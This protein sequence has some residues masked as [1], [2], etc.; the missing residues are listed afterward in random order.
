VANEQYDLDALNT[1]LDEL[2]FVVIRDAIPRDQ[3]SHM[4]ERLMAIMRG[5]PEA[6]KLYQNLR[7]VFNYDAEDTFVPL[8][9]HPAVLEIS[10]H[11]VGEGMQMA[12]VG[13]L[14][15]KPG[16][17][18]GRLHA[19]VPIGWF[20]RTGR[21]IPDTC[22]MVNVIWMLTEFTA[23]NGGTVFLPCSHTSRRV[24]R[25]GVEYPYLV[26][27]TGTPGSFVIFNG[28]IWHGSGPNVTAKSERLGVSAGYFAQWMD[29][30]AGGWYLLTREVRDRMPPEVRA[31]NRHVVDRPGQKIGDADL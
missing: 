16:A 30:R 14:W 20:A 19:D 21:P 1:E 4:G 13:A 27:V 18:A 9:N 31:M 23:E 2:G 25:A 29:P 26:P 15:N 11:A 3:A 12:E 28:S 17:T 5:R 10:R 22:F 7:G 6:D 24:P 8:V